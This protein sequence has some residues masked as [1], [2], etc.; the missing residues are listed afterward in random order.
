VVAGI[1]LCGPG[2]EQALAL[3]GQA[4]FLE[5]FA[6]VLEGADILLHCETQHSPASYRVLLDNSRAR[7]W[8]AEM[9]PG[10]APVGYLVVAP[11][12]LPLPDLSAD[13]LEVKRI[14]LLHSVQGRGLGK[15]L[16]NEAIGYARR[17]GSRRLLLGVYGHND[18]AIGFYQMI[19]FRQV[20]VRKFRVG[21]NEYDD[22]VLGL[23]LPTTLHA[24]KGEVPMDPDTPR[25]E[26]R[27]AQL[28]RSLI[29]EFLRMNGF[30]A[31]SVLKLPDEKRIAMLTQAA[32]YAA[33]K[34]AEVEARAHYL[35]DIHGASED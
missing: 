8:M 13:D 26:D 21:R 2:D 14:Y 5:A 35:H 23:D 3:V 34:L 17:A 16:M 18:Q 1:R 11:A 32:E 4:T 22:L 24:A 29:D 15:Q 27:Y 6:G 30:D 9:Q 28:E 20:G 25:M 31:E 33:V 19:G 12:N 7:T 10:G